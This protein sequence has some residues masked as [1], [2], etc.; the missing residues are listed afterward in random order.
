MQMKQHFAIKGQ[1]ASMHQEAMSRKD[2]E[3]RKQSCG[4]AKLADSSAQCTGS[5]S[6]RC[7]LKFRVFDASDAAQRLD[8]G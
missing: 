3:D 8:V 5:P 7:G 6:D 4:A 2:A 1:F